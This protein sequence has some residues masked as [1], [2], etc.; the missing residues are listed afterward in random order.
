LLPAGGLRA[1]LPCRA[2]RRPGAEAAQGA[3]GREEGRVR[4]RGPG[5]ARIAIDR[6]AAGRPFYSGKHKRHG[7][8]LQVIASPTGDIPWVSGALPGSVHDKKVNWARASSTNWRPPGRS[9]SPI[10]VDRNHSGRRSRTGERT[11][12]NHRKRPTALTRS[13]APRNQDGKA[14]CA[15]P[16]RSGG[17]WHKTRPTGQLSDLHA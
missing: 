10:R 3:A 8:N 15:H 14:Q 2:A 1:F 11:S 13:S 7:M 4:L 9:P 6:V 12:Q 5:R 17:R 16:S